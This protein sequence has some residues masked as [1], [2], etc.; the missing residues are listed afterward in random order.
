MQPENMY[1]PAEHLPTLV[2]LSW[3]GDRLISQTPI[4]AISNPSSELTIL[5]TGDLH[6][7][8]DGKPNDDGTIY[9][10][11]ARI[12]TTIRQA[13]SAGPTLVLDTGDLV[14]GEGTRWN[15]HGAGAVAQLRATAGCDLATIGNHDVERG[16]ISLQELIE[17]GIRFVS[18]NLRDRK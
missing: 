5:H 12:A 1:I 14:F 10:G 7:S 9:G 4:D 15:A 13:R 6:S 17:E 2:P 8:V 16:H 11:L 18:A 3:N